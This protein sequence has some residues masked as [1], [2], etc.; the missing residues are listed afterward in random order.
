LKV[1]I[2][3]GG[4]HSHIQKVEIKA[5]VKLLKAIATYIYKFA[6]IKVFHSM[7]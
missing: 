1:Y 3:L 7:V 2:V 4:E 6:S 5:R